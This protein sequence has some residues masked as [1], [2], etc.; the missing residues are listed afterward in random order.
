MR[1]KEVIKAGEKED[2]PKQ[3]K[4][5]IIEYKNA[6]EKYKMLSAETDAL[7]KAKVAKTNENCNARET[8]KGFTFKDTPACE[9]YFNSVAF[10]SA[11]TT[12]QCACQV[13]HKLCADLL[14]RSGRIVPEHWPRLHHDLFSNW[15]SPFSYNA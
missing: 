8:A 14:G 12:Y 5:A 13:F 9:K 10:R 15:H 6:Q 1:I 2:A 3:F 11:L 4:K 7:I